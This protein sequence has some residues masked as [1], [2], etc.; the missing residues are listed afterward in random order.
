VELI[1]NS[2][3]NAAIREVLCAWH[4]FRSSLLYFIL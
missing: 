3:L 1:P 2:I 4:F